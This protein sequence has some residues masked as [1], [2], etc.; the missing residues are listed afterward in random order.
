LKRFTVNS[1]H[2]AA[3]RR[4]LLAAPLGAVAAIAPTLSFASANATVGVLLPVNERIPGMKLD[5]QQGFQAEL[6]AADSRQRP[7]F[8]PY[9]VGS[10]RALAAAQSLLDQGCTALTGIFNRNLAT[11]LSDSLEKRSANFFVSD[12]GANAVRSN[13][14]CERLTRVGP[15]LW[16]HAYLAGQRAAQHG[17]RHAVIATSFYEA[18][19]DLPGAFKQGFIDAGGTDATIVV[20]GT[21]DLHAGDG[22]ERITSALAARARP[23]DVLFSLYSGRE[24]ARYLAFAHTLSSRVGSMVALSPLLHGMPKR[25]YTALPLDVFSASVAGVSQQGESLYA[26]M[27]RVAARS[28]LAARGQSC[29][30]DA[31]WTA[32]VTT[33]VASGEKGRELASV[34]PLRANLSAPWQ[35]P[36]L[37]GWIAPY[38]A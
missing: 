23:V 6:M 1:G 36:S 7:H 28:V 4:L 11:H 18:G 5:W 38:G 8:L 14:A 34:W 20:T 37:S 29:G 32:A 35:S 3:R 24:A 10:Y 13:A 15:S 9:A 30:I 12:L 26:S 19:Y 25:A 2:S 33:P 27:G 21:P 22:F 17:A 31:T 16:Q